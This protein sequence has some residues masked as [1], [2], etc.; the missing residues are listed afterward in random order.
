MKRNGMVGSII[1]LGAVVMLG[2][3][4]A[5]AIEMPTTGL[6]LWLE[7]DAITGLTNGEAVTAWPDSVN[8]YNATN[9]GVLCP[10]WQTNQIN[11]KP[12][13]RFDG[14]TN[15]LQNAAYTHGA[16]DVTLFVVAKRNG[17]P[18]S[19][20]HNIFVGGPATYKSGTGSPGNYYQIYADGATMELRA[21]AV[22][23]GAIN[24][25]VKFTN[26]TFQILASWK[27][28]AASSNEF[29]I[30]GTSRGTKA[31]ATTAGAKFYIGNWNNNPMHGDIAE[32]ALYNTALSAADRQLVEGLMA[33][34]YGLEGSLPPGHA[35]RYTDP[36]TGKPNIGN[37]ASSY[38]RAATTATVNGYLY[39]TGF[40]PTTVSVY[41]GDQDGGAPTSGVWQYTNTFAEGQWAAGTYPSSSIALPAPNT[42]YYYRYAATNAGGAAWAPSSQSF[43]ASAR[44]VITNAAPTSVGGSSATLNGYLSYTSA[45][46]TTVSVYWGSVDGGAPTSG[47]WQYTNTFAE[48]Q[49]AEGSTP[50]TNVALPTPNIS[51][52]YRFYA[53]NSG[54]ESW[55]AVSQSF[56]ASGQFSWIQAAAGTHYWTNSA[57]WSPAFIPNA[58]SAVVAITNERAGAQTIT[59]DQTITL[60]RLVVGNTNTI[61]ITT[62]QTG[63]AF[64]FNNVAASP[65]I[66]ISTTAGSSMTI[67]ATNCVGAELVISNA[68]DFTITGSLGG[69]TNLVKAGTGYLT[70]SGPH[71]YTGDLVIKAG[72]V[73]ASEYGSV[74]VPDSSWI[75]LE[76]GAFF[77][78]QKV[79]ETIKG[80]R[81]VG[82]VYV[83][84][85]PVSIVIGTNSTGT[86]TYDVNLVAGGELRPGFDATVGDLYLNRSATAG[87][88]GHILGGDIYLDVTGPATF[89]RIMFQYGASLISAG[90]LHL[91]FVAPYVPTNGAF[92]D[93]F[94]TVTSGSI[95]DTTPDDP[96]FTSIDSTP[97]MPNTRFDAEILTSNKVRVTLV[98]LPRGS[99]VI[100]R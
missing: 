60:G 21:N 45:F 42:T 94:N 61:A 51:Y 31:G 98:V 63:G 53:T 7:A 20:Y 17:N 99:M 25:G 72:R 43:F 8:G 54:G 37:D 13:V 62:N 14:F 84:G 34:K 18:V 58:A 9:S 87:A 100:L 91:N 15:Y 49:W 44:P 90:N 29:F 78:M 26:T 28:Y 3:L 35:W 27:S 64:L 6:R 88:N 23:I 22:T 24:S 86:T 38:N 67:G 32:V 89:D 33:W 80:V 56:F 4:T 92:W 73:Y 65:S 77:R 16:N 97:V 71:R 46:P 12:V 10:T 2:A 41:W 85:Q 76:N 52:F 50:G 75:Q 19:G 47:V 11:G 1:M 59:V 30:D 69:F 96:L 39:S 40:Y 66:E 57:N 36:A 82:S 68:V 48:G 79:G 83:N 55:P 74:L 81:G 70:M 95:A 5:Q 93:I